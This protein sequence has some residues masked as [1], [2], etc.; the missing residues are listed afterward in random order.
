[1]VAKSNVPFVVPVTD[2]QA[3]A[4]AFSSLIA[5]PA[6]RHTIG[7][8]NRERARSDYCEADM[9]ARYAALYG[10]AMGRP[11]ILTP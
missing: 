2:E 5:D 10:S 8:D 9:V 3:I 7:Q 6:L 11:H 1:M 4:D